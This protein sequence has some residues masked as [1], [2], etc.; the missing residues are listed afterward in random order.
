[1][2]P[3]YWARTALA[4]VVVFFILLGALH[5]IEPEFDLQSASSA[6]M[7]LAAMVG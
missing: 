3:R 2:N 7:N 5:F 1:M 4:A 6:S